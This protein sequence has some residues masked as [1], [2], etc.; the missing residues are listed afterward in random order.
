MAQRFRTSAGTSAAQIIYGMRGL[1]LEGTPI[2]IEPEALAG[3]KPP[4]ILFMEP[5]H[6]LQAGHIVAFVGRDE[7]R[8]VVLDPLSGRT[9]G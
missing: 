8:F 3:L 2:T 4:A 6:P 5:R 7:H 9:V 1:G